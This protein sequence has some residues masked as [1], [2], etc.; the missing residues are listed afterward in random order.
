M[1]Y[2]ELHIGDYETATAHLTACEDGIYGRLMRRYYSTE[3]PLPLELKA[4]QRLVRARTRE[5]KEAVETILEEFFAQADD[6]WHHARCDAE[7]ARYREKEPDREAKKENARERQRRARERRAELFEELR[8]HGIVPPYDTSTT[9]LQALL[10]R[11]TSRPVTPLVTR[12]VT[13]TQT[14]GTINQEPVDLQ[15]ADRS[16]TARTEPADRPA[17][18]SDPSAAGS[19]C[20]AMRRGGL[21][22]T[23]PSHPSLL[24]AIAEG[25]TDAMWEHTAREAT[26]QGKGFAWVIATIRGRLGDAARQP[27]TGAPHAAPRSRDRRSLADQVVMPDDHAGD[28]RRTLAGT[29]TRIPHR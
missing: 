3:E 24:A 16:L 7:I 10:S 25:A 23:N 8:G 17:P 20:L 28:D 1:N 4:V 15:R 18:K 27:T 19:A 2:F 12:D 29:A 22:Q 21:A 26:E 9:A 13:A 6:G 5:E 14:P 11:A